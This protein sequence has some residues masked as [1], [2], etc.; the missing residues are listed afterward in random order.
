MVY[1]LKAATDHLSLTILEREENNDWKVEARSS[2]AADAL[3]VYAHA[4]TRR[5]A[6]ARVADEWTQHARSNRV[7]F[8]DWAAV[9]TAL[10]AVRAL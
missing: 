5:D 7:P 3:V 4:Q 1:D 6:I 10:E 2:N 9:V 8:F